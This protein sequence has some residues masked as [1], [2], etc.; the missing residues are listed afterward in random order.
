MEKTSSCVECGTEFEKD[1]WPGRPRITCSVACYKQRRNRQIASWRAK[2]LCPDNLHGTVT[3]YST[4]A[5]DC[6]PCK[7]ANTRYARQR[8]QKEKTA[9]S[10]SGKT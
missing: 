2:T 10:E 6:G 8:R 3:G 1:S 4:Y 7:E 5:C 9:R